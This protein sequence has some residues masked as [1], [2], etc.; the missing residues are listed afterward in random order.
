MSWVEKN[1]KLTIG[2]DDYLGFESSMFMR[3][4]FFVSI[5]QKEY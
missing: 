3:G 1:E 4:Y 2:G 5:F